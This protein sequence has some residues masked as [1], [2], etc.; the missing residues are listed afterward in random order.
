M[1]TSNDYCFTI[2]MNIKRY[3]R[4]AGMS[5]EELA[6]AADLSADYMRHLEAENSPFNPTNDVMIR[7]ADALETTLYRCYVR[8][9]DWIQQPAVT[10]EDGFV[11]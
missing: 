5:Q 3:R 7:I 9:E 4:E 10:D 8:E 2:K 6:E 1:K 11:I